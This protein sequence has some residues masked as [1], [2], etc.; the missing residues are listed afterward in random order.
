MKFV[1][2]GERTCHY[3]EEVG[4]FMV[5]F[6]IAQLL[7]EYGGHDVKMISNEPHINGLFNDYLRTRVSWGR[8]QKYENLE[9]RM[10]DICNKVEEIQEIDTENTIAIYGEAIVG[11]PCKCKKVIRILFSPLGTHNAKTHFNF[12]NKTDMVWYYNK[13]E[14]FKENLPNFYK[15]FNVV[16]ISESLRLHYNSPESRIGRWCHLY[17]KGHNLHEHMETL[18]PEHSILIDKNPDFPKTHKE[19]CE[20]FTNYEYFVCYDPYTFFVFMALK[21]GCKVIL[22]KYKN[23]TKK[24][25]INQAPF[26][27]KSENIKGL[28]Y[29]ID[30]IEWADETIRKSKKQLNSL[31]KHVDD[32]NKMEIDN[33]IKNID[34]EN[35]VANVYTFHPNVYCI[36]DVNY[37]KLHK[38]L[39]Q[40][41]YYLCGP[42]N[43]GMYGV[44]RETRYPHTSG[45]RDVTEEFYG[46]FAFTGENKLFF[47]LYPLMSF[48]VIYKV[49]KEAAILYFGTT[50]DKVFNKDVFDFFENETNMTKFEIEKD[51]LYC[52]TRNERHIR[53]IILP[54]LRE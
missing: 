53:R 45:F 25:W 13:D 24:E 23:L 54:S 1:I 21:A 48:K 26:I 50:T 7:K 44:Y 43:D 6:K 28:A 49:C 5:I 12:W 9:T 18:H 42:N 15:I 35:T 40:D 34:G 20:F 22:H 38:E 8:R 30:D 27:E 46:V 17:K 19:I 52:F 47:N 14:T 41:S 33:F 31:I 3:N 32:K 11:N 36:G 16:Y 4:G 29:G 51:E 2:L 10:S 37:K 39:G